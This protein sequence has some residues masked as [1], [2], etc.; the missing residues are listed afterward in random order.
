MTSLVNSM[1]ENVTKSMTEQIESPEIKNLNVNSQ[2]GLILISHDVIDLGVTEEIVARI[3]EGLKEK[4]PGVELSGAM[5]LE[6]M[7]ASQVQLIYPGLKREF[8]D[9]F[10]KT[11]GEMPS[12][13][14]AFEQTD[15]EAVSFDFIKEINSIKGKIK[16]HKTRDGDGGWGKSIRSAIPLPGDRERYEEMDRKLD[17]G[18]LSDDDYVKLTHHLVHS[19][20][21][22]TE[23]AGLYLLIDTNTKREMFGDENMDSYDRWAQK[24]TSK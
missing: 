16:R 13:L 19:P 10:T 3:L 18:T 4:S 9:A 11:L 1:V 14:V 21:N 24:L 6:G 2:F 15:P 5:T 22:E 17:Q 8:L 20:D 12:V 23:L 7:T